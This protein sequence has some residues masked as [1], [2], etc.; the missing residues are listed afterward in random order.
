MRTDFSPISL[1]ECT[2]STGEGLDVRANA[3]EAIA[4][5]ISRQIL[6]HHPAGPD[7]EMADLRVTH[8]SG[9]EA[10][11]PARGLQK[12]VR[13]GGPQAVEN[14]GV[15]LTDGVVGTVFP[16]APAVH[17]DQ[18]DRTTCLHLFHHPLPR[19]RY[20]SLQPPV[21]FDQEQY[22]LVLM[23]DRSS[24]VNQ[25]SRPTDADA[26]KWSPDWSISGN[27]GHRRR[28]TGRLNDAAGVSPWPH[29]ITD[30]GFSL[31]LQ[32]GLRASEA[33]PASQPSMARLRVR[34]QW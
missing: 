13:T 10:D 16:A 11:V 24:A 12:R 7:I 3:P 20:K 17:D 30:P 22:S 2:E 32:S 19:R 26:P 25:P 34:P 33:F 14:G 31:T 15:G 5:P 23:R 1:A 18:H 6:H 9:R 21:A 4:S 29:H 28:L 27:P 8:L